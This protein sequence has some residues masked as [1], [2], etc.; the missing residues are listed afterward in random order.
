MHTHTH[1]HI[2]FK[3]TTELEKS[4]GRLQNEN[5]IYTKANSIH[6][7]LHCVKFIVLNILFLV[8]EEEKQLDIEFQTSK[9][10]IK[11]I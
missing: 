3:I 10:N 2:Y 6:I 11:N 7:K 8:K 4:T 5:I 9:I 1:I